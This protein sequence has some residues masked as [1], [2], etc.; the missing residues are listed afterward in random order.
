MNI[1]DIAIALAGVAAIAVAVGCESEGGGSPDTQRPRV[2]K[3][4]GIAFGPPVNCPQRDEYGTYLCGA[5]T[6]SVTLGTT[7]RDGDT[8]DFYYCVFTQPG[9]TSVTGGCAFDEKC[10]VGH[11]ASMGLDVERTL[12]L[13]AS[14]AQE[15]SCPYHGE[16]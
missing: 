1:R 14:G 10:V 3:A 11:D 7:T 4:A 2:E 15:F 13:T 12:A 8:A 6:C 16:G 5:V 9:C